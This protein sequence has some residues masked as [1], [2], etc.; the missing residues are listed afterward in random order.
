MV[1]WVASQQSKS[2]K[3]HQKCMHVEEKIDADF[4]IGIKRAVGPT[5][6]GL[7]GERIPI[8][9][10]HKKLCRDKATTGELIPVYQVTSSLTTW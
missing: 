3:E 1:G 4:E 2:G 9:F 8:A 6:K 7:A 5:Q 10:E